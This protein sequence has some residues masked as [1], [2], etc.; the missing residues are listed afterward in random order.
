[1]YSGTLKQP[2]SNRKKIVIIAVIAV[3]FCLSASGGLYYMFK[4]SSDRTDEFGRRRRDW[5]DANLPNP[6]KQ[7]PQEIMAYMD[8]AEFKKLAPR[9]QFEYMRQGGRQ[10][11][12]YQMETYFS[13]GDEKQKTAYLDQMIDRMQAERANFEQMRG[14]MPRRQRDANEPNDPNR[15]S[16][17]QAQAGGRRTQTAS[18]M[19]ARSERGT[20]LQRAQRDAFMTAMRK[21]M[22]QRGI[23][24][25]GPGGR[26]GPGGPPPGR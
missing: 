24:T 8:S 9:K 22:Q 6:D 18:G 5:R 4:G 2:P 7:K 26:G 10:V 13:L 15:P 19:R 21:R 17:R 20:A 25:P 1:M 3:V 11:M 14:Q 16:R 23:T 12:E